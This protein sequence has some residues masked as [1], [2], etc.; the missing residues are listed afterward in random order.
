MQQTFKSF[1][2]GL[3][4]SLTA[5]ALPAV[6]LTIEPYDAAKYGE[7]LTAGRT[8]VLDFHADWCGTCKKQASVLESLATDPALENVTV[9]KVD[10]DAAKDLRKEWNVRKQSTLV[11]VDQSGEIAR[12]TG[13]TSPKRITSLMT[14]AE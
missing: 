9:L 4:F 8:V 13:E 1:V 6:A 7:A 10:F 11:V 14:R 2:M 3:A 12:A 5:S